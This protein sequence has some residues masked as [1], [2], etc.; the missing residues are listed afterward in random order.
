M[1]DAGET[2]TVTNQADIDKI[3][4]YMDNITFRRK[5]VL[6]RGGWSY[7]FDFNHYGDSLGH[8]V[9]AGS[10]GSIDSKDYSY[11]DSNATTMEEMLNNLTSSKFVQP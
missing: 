8:F 6:P 11:K 5:F 7:S 2:M 3:L 10:S 4:D 9:F 1:N